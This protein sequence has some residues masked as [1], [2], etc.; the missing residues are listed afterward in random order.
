MTVAYA[1]EQRTRDI[2][3]DALRASVNLL[4]LLPAGTPVKRIGRDVHVTLCAFH[5]EDRPSMRITRHKGVDRFRCFPCGAN[6]DAI[7][8]VMKSR[9]LSFKAAL[10]ELAGGRTFD[11]SVTTPT[12]RKAPPFLLVCDTAGCTATREVEAEDVPYLGETIGIA[13]HVRPTR[14][15]CP[16]CV[17]AKR[18]WT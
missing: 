17:R 14:V 4:D 2:D 8:F 9:G 18:G 3:V 15:W 10:L 1:P 7:D 6:G 5:A 11:L 16:A 13:W 12:R